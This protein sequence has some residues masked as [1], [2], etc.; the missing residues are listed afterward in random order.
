MSRITALFKISKSFMEVA[1]LKG[2][3]SDKV[4]VDLTDPASAFTKRGMCAKA[5]LDFGVARMRG[6]PPRHG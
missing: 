3:P 1:I 4:T 5:V 6:A 2:H